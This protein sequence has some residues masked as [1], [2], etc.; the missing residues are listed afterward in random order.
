MTMATQEPVSLKRTPLYERHAALGGK[1]VDFGGFELPLY[2]TAILREHER[3]RSSCG[4]FDVSHLGE[5]RVTGPKAFD[6][7]QRMVPNDLSGLGQGRMLYSIL[8]TD[9]G[10][11]L[12]DI[13]IYRASADAF[14][15]VVNAST[16]GRDYAHMAAHA[17]PGVELRNDSDTVACVAVQGPSSEALCEKVMGPGL[18][19]LKYY[20]FKPLASWGKSAWVSRS[21][22]TGEDG[23]E[24]FSDNATIVKIWDTLLEKGKAWGLEPAGIGAR[25]T[26]RLEAG[27]GL[28]GHDVDETL[29][30]YEGRLGRLVDESKPDF[31][32]KAALAERK[33]S[34]RRRLCGFRIKSDKAVPRDGYR[35]LKDGREAGIVTSGSFSPTLKTGIGLARVNSELTT[36]G[37]TFD[38]EIHG[39]AVAAEVVKLP[40][41][42]LKHK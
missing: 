17:G 13:L 36:V 30:P 32:G 24:F 38:I 12:D 35:I 4:I 31:V 41:V 6:Y 10:G 19:S 7:L 39:R 11:V 42:P 40:F 14:Y 18:A 1:L 29:T 34:V 27:N 33:K 23:F 22:Y 9:K 2:Y 25:N 37:S 26:L 5:I 3:V 21:G 8:L 16:S 20:E 28:Y 15:V